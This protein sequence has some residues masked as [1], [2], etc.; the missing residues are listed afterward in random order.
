MNSNN[1]EKKKLE[2]VNLYREKKFENVLK[3]GINLLKKK[4]ND[5]QLIFI[6]GLTTINLQNYLE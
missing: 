2:I 4:P 5:S 6:L 3:S 1:F